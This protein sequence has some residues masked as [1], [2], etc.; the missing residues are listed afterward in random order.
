MARDQGRV[1]PRQGS[2]GESGASLCRSTQA[3]SG[4]RDLVDLPVEFVVALLVCL[5]HGSGFVHAYVGSFVG[6]EPERRSVLDLS[7]GCLVSV[8]EDRARSAEAGLVGG[9]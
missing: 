9:D 5:G 3:T 1:R 4:Q 6:G 8:D 7:L 2:W